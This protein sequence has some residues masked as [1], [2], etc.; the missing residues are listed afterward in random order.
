MTTLLIALCV[1]I[2]LG[3]TVIVLEILPCSVERYT[4]STRDL[5]NTLANTAHPQLK[6]EKAP[7]RR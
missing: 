3:L 5:A 6:S 7:A 4:I 2:A 1:L